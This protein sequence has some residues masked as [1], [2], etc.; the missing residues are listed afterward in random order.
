[1]DI[2]S[3]FDLLDA[4]TRDGW[5]RIRGGRFWKHITDEGLD[6]DLY[7]TVM[8][9]VF[10]YTRHN[11]QNQALAA[12]NVLSD[13]LPLLQFCLHHA[14][15][16][17]GHDLMVLEDLRSIGVDP[18][19]V[20]QSVPLP[21]TQAF[22]A[23]LYRLAAQKDPIARVGYSY[24]AEGS[25]EHIADLIGAMR[26]D[27]RL[28]D[29]QMTFFVE[30]A[31]IDTAHFDQVKKIVRQFCVNEEQQRDLLEALTTTLHLQGNMIEGAF[32]AYLQSRDSGRVRER[33][34]A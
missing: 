8:T 30:H 20:L 31:V 16:E 22:I 4:K 18:E 13:R 29:D 12:L 6:R 23:Y 10:H 24:W 19:T 11:A 32:D 33:E 1:M 26:R 7:V 34:F 28:H 3:F 25:Y 15:S 21:D 17:A 9:E 27:L 2:E 5:K 14:Y